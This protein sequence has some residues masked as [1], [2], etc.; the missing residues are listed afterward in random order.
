MSTQKAI[1]YDSECPLCAAYTKAFVKLK[2]LR[3]EERIAFSEL[4]DQEF[5]PRMDRSR[6]GNEIPLV[7]LNG[8]KTLYGLDALVFLLSRRWQWIGRTMR[9]RPLY[10]F[11]RGLYAMISYNRRV[12]LAKKFRAITCS[13]A[14]DYHA[15][16]R[17]LLIA[18]AATVSVLI[19]HG[20]GISLAETAGYAG[21]Y[22]GLKMLAICGTGWMLSMATAVAFM[23]KDR[24][25]YIG[26][27][28]V[29]QLTG[30]FVLVPATIAAPY[31]GDA[32]IYLCLCS[33]V[34][35]SLLMLRGH[36]RRIAIMGRSQVWT[37]LWFVFLQVSAAAWALYFFNSK[38][39]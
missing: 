1:I 21:R 11:F 32:G 25:E 37:L 3:P 33:V 12:I 5:I 36:A 30:V 23:K 17:V 13:C 26:H 29:L 28:A 16:Y 8:G 2:L 39:V 9:F 7:D 34:V 31:I 19:T 15:G 35:S 27:L 10:L 18:F 24:L 20:F 14:P 4:S 22:P 38:N 6:Q